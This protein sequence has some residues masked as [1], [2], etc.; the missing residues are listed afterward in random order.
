[1]GPR[2]FARTKKCSQICRKSQYQYHSEQL[3]QLSTNLSLLPWPCNRIQLTF[4]TGKWTSNMSVFLTSFSHSSFGNLHFLWPSIL[5]IF[6]SP[7]T[8]QQSNTWII[9]DWQ[10][11]FLVYI[12]AYPKTCSVGGETSSTATYPRVAQPSAKPVNWGCDPTLVA[13][14]S[15]WI[16]MMNIP[17]IYVVVYHLLNITMAHCKITTLRSVFF[18]FST[19][20]YHM[21]YHTSCLLHN[22]CIETNNS[23]QHHDGRNISPSGWWSGPTCAPAGCCGPP[24]RLGPLDFF[25]NVLQ[26]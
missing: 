11:L 4:Q 17:W 26:L 22:W 15:T 13:R 9:P 6:F 25:C 10:I 7:A 23:K 3:P 1:M 12:A 5:S 24:H 21:V 19:F 16:H 2:S 14:D 8:L 20:V 18:T